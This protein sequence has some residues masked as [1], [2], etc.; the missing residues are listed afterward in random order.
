MTPPPFL[1]PSLV[2]YGLA[3]LLGGVSR[4]PRVAGLDTGWGGMLTSEDDVAR[5]LRALDSVL[6]LLNLAGYQAPEVVMGIPTD[7]SATAAADL[8]SVDM[9]TM[10]LARGTARAWTPVESQAHVSLWVEPRFPAAP[11]LP[12]SPT[13]DLSGLVGTLDADS[14]DLEFVVWGTGWLQ[15]T[16]PAGQTDPSWLDQLGDQAATLVDG[17]IGELDV[18]NSAAAGIGNGPVVCGLL[19]AYDS[20][21]W[22]MPIPVELDA[23]LLL[24]GVAQFGVRLGQVVD[25]DLAGFLAAETSPAPPTALDRWQ[26]GLDDDGRNAAIED[27]GTSADELGD[28]GLDAGSGDDGRMQEFAR[29]AYDAFAELPVTQLLFLWEALGVVDFL[30]FDTGTK[31]G[32][33]IDDGAGGRAP[34]AGGWVYVRNGVSGA[35][36]V[37]LTDASGQMR[38]TKGNVRDAPWDYTEPFTA[39]A[40]SGLWFAYSRG[41]RPIPDRLLTDPAFEQWYMQVTIPADE[42]TPIT[43]PDTHIAVT[44][45]KEL[46]LWP[47]LWFVSSAADD[48][49]LTD[50]L[51]QTRN[52]LKE[53]DFAP[54]VAPNS[55][56]APKLRGLVVQ[57]T[58]DALAVSVEIEIV[59]HDGTT[60]NQLQSLQANAPKVTRATATLGA[61]TGPTRSFDA[62]VVLDPAA[63]PKSFGDVQI[64]VVRHGPDG[65]RAEAVSELLTGVQIALVDDTVPTVRGDV[66][67]VAKELVVVDFKDSPQASQVAIDGQTRVRRMIPYKIDIVQGLFDPNKPADPTANPAIPKPRM[68]RWMAEAELA[69][70]DHLALMDMMRRRAFRQPSPADGTPKPLQKLALALDWKLDL[71]WDGPDGQST[72]RQYSYETAIDGSQSVQLL[73][74]ANGDLVDT[75]RVPIQIGPDGEIPGALP[76]NPRPAFVEPNRRRPQVLVDKANRVWGRT[77]ADEA[78]CLVVEWQPILSDSGR[79][80]QAGSRFA[81]GTAA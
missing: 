31:G 30:A 65:A 27:L 67:G 79:G 54:A 34:L 47:L 19:G 71:K 64:V 44:T 7:S 59:A 66:L 41:A 51:A 25:G 39:K 50:G 9:G 21:T 70:A 24:P 78:S 6:L 38:S 58:V 14:F 74:D 16:W 15:I 10:A 77:G 81:A 12:P 20:R 52:A 62:T 35:V 5:A 75:G 56:A 61:P 23:S 42:S 69:G 29:S 68:P 11:G 55:A 63:L 40:G 37:F 2:W 22:T 43:L 73:F 17:L 28:L 32:I 13:L 3:P 57:G 8:V 18:H 76:V 4:R 36:A 72:D 49:Y 60:I 1:V 45:P 46:E 48:P 26:E 53:G 33:V 80:G